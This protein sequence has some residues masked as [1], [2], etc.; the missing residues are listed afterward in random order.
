MKQIIVIER[1]WV[2]VGNCVAKRGFLDI[3]EG[4]VIRHWGTERGLGQLAIEG[5]TKTTVLEPTGHIIVPMTSVIMRI[6]VTA[7]GF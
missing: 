7:K 6:D 4:S 1:G 2:V 5:P 3:T